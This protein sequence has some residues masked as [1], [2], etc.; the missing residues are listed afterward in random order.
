MGECAQLSARGP[1]HR[2]Q[3]L[4]QAPSSPNSAPH[5]FLHNPHDHKH[6]SL[7]LHLDKR[8][9]VTSFW[10]SRALKTGLPMIP[11]V[12]VPILLPEDSPSILPIIYSF[13]HRL[14]AFGGRPFIHSKSV[15]YLLCA[16]HCARYWGPIMNKIIHLCF[17]GRYR[18]ITRQFPYSG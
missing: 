2:A 4:F 6:H 3:P 1:G 13:K 12:P 8:P 10:H 11:L 9:A 15:K 18:Q 7:Q 16:R 17:C 5:L 14:S